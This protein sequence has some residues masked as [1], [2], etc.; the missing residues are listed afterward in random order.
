MLREL[1]TRCGNYRQL[2]EVTVAKSVSQELNIYRTL[3]ANIEKKA[4]ASRFLLEQ[5]AWDLFVTVFGEAHWA[6]HQFF[7]H[8]DPTHWAHD[9]RNVRRLSEAL[10]NIYTELDAHLA[11]L[12]Q[13]I[14]DATVFV[15]SVHGIAS[16]FSGNHLLPQILQK[17][18]FQTSPARTNNHGGV[19]NILNGT[20]WLRN[21]IPGSLR[22]FIN[23]RI[24]PQDFHDGVF[25]H[26]YS[27][28]IDWKTTKAFVLP[29]SFF[30]GFISIN[31]R[32]R[33]PWGVV[34]P[35]AEYDRICGR[36]CNELMQLRIP[37]TG[38]RAVR[39]VV[40]IA[41]VY[42]GD[43]LYSL[44]D[45]VIQ[46]AEDGPIDQVFHPKFGL[47]SE[48]D[49]E[50]RKARHADDGFMIAAGKHIRKNT[51]VVGASTTDLAPTVL[52]LMG[53]P[54]P[55][56]MDGH[57]LLDMIDEDFTARHKV[58]YQDTPLATADEM[59]V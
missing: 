3:R 8:S 53:Q 9:S 34:E 29:K 10:P 41:H 45:L 38:A 7:H 20:S 18:G 48:R 46:W 16:N 56:E 36:L 19:T 44:P 6:G 52:Y 37:A 14:D 31:L 25:F 26:N 23:N 40:R 50:R 51:L 11:R 15:F 59:G 43:R 57:P 47:I 30:E 42:E 21:C 54:I 35:G 55:N 1:V 13:D 58:A 5:D 32:G 39:D 49:P 33:E 17:L 4:A 22:E 2:K 28:A 12:L 24:V 27:A